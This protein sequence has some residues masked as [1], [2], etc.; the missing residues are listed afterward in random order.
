[1]HYKTMRL[2]SAVMLAGMAAACSI[3]PVEARPVRTTNQVALTVLPVGHQTFLVGKR[4]YFAHNGIYYRATGN[5]Y[6]VVAA[7]AGA[8]VATLR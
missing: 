4:R 2:V 3:A 8:I 7:P 1:M 6:R 5:G